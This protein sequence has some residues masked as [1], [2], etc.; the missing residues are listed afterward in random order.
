M[1]R[2]DDLQKQL[3]D[4]KQCLDKLSSKSQQ[5]F[6]LQFTVLYITHVFSG[7]PVTKCSNGEYV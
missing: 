3:D 4:V 6:E 2:L 1:Q 5:Q 7:E